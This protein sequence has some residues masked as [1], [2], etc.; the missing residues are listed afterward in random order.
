[1]TR[2]ALLILCL[3]LCGDADARNN[4]DVRHRQQPVRKH[5]LYGDNQPRRHVV[6]RVLEY[7][8]V[9]RMHGVRFRARATLQLHSMTVQAVFK[10]DSRAHVCNNNI[11][12]LCNTDANCAGGKCIRNTNS[13]FGGSVVNGDI[14]IDGNRVTFV[15]NFARSELRFRKNALWDLRFLSA[16]PADIQIDHVLKVRDDS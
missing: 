11:A 12:K 1:M 5:R 15:S 10:P 6:R 2:V 8:F 13:G 9:G 16:T 14:L 7:V 4:P 3:A